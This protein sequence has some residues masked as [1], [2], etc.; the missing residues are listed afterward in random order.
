V[1]EYT[2]FEPPPVGIS[3]PVMAGGA[4]PDPARGAQMDREIL[5]LMQQSK[6]EDAVRSHAKDQGSFNV[7][8]YESLA[9]VLIRAYAQAAEGKGAER[10]AQGLSF[11]EQPMQQLIRLYGVG[12][13]LG[14]AAKKAQE[15][16][17]L[18]TVE[19]QVS[20]LLGAIN[21]L[22]GAVIA[23]ERGGSK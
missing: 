16:Q 11:D 1:N 20:E 13:A 3:M 21:Y 4:A 5:A 23:L 12:F 10:H 22:A 18:P 19:R 7:D 15:A 8:G 9:S 6:L 14:Q 17:R 2:K